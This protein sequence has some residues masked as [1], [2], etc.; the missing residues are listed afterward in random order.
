[1][2]KYSSTL[3]KDISDLLNSKLTFRDNFAANLSSVTFSGAV[4]A[5]LSHSLRRMPTGYIVYGKSA[6]INVY[7]GATA[8]TTENLYLRASGAGTVKVLVF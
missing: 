2:R 8:N 6:D 3:L 5:R 4:E 7:D 1:L